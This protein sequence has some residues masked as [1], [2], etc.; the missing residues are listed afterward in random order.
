MNGIRAIGVVLLL[1]G[2]LA[3]VVPMPHHEDHSV[4]IGDAR[5]GVETEHSKKLPQVIGG[6]L[7]AGGVLALL[8]GSRKA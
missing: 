1:L 4:K 7:L 6:A 2:I 8:L 3:F 5:I